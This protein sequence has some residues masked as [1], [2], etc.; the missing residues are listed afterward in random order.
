MTGYKCPFSIVLAPGTCHCRLAREVVRR[1]GAEFDCKEPAAHAQCTE[2]A[3]HLNTRALPALGYADDLTQTPKSV[4]E[5]VLLGGLQGLRMAQDAGDSALETPDIRTVV[6]K[7]GAG[8]GAL[9]GIPDTAF[10][11]AI[12]ACAARKRQRRRGS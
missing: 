4:Y 1:G 3:A 2:L 11:P 6:E 7:L 8:Y 9:T 5:R 10:L 12:E